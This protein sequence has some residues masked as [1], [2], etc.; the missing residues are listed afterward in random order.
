MGR[1]FMGF[2]G[3]FTSQKRTLTV[4]SPFNPVGDW[5]AAYA[6]AHPRNPGAELVCDF[7]SKVLNPATGRFSYSIT[8][9]NIGPGATFF[10]I[11]F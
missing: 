5:G 3:P 1:F 10:D 11:D 8:V 4:T 2:I 9:R 6:L 7:H